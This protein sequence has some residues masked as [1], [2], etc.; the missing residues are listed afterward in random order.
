M[1][2]II[3]FSKISIFISILINKISLHLASI[4]IFIII[5]TFFV[6]IVILKCSKNLFHIYEKLSQ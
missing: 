2:I 4:L 1:K 6:K 5:I 3:F